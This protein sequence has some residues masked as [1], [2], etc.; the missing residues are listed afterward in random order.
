MPNGA[1]IPKYFRYLYLF[2]KF[3]LKKNT[4]YF[5]KAC[6]L[7]VFKSRKIKLIA[8]HLFFLLKIVPYR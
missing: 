2:D 6:N 8:K 4:S 1:K 3:T 5:N 7:N